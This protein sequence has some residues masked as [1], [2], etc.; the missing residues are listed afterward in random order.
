M[1]AELPGPLDAAVEGL[2]AADWRRYATYLVSRPDEAE[3]AAIRLMIGLCREFGTRVHIVHLSSARGIELLRAARAEGLPVT[4]ETCPHYLHFQAE[5]IAD[6]ATLFK[7]AP[8]IR[9]AANRELLWQGLR[10]GVIDL[11][12]SDHSPCPPEMKRLEQGNFEA[13]WGGIAS[14]SLCLP[15]IWTEMQGRGLSLVELARW[16]SGN[17]AKLAGLAH[18]KGQITEGMDADLVVLEPEA[19]F[20]V[21]AE[22]LHFRHAVS[23]YVGESLM[24]VVR[25]TV[26]RGE[27]IF[28]DGRV[29]GAAAGR[30]VS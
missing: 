17:P 30:E 1:H 8:P 5:Q 12:A 19:R 16:M 26:L 21:E 4:V 23:P 9:S 10:E 29:M 13:A 24:G 28:E 2:E 27:R 11:I 18:C 22:R 14:L 25:Q 3:L 7:C 15:V 6:G 20:V